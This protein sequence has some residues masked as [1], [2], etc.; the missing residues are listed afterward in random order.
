V[1]V[2]IAGGAGFLGSHLT[3]LHVARGDEVVVLDDFTTG[4]REN[5][6]H[7]ADNSAVEIIAA[8]VSVEVPVSGSVDRVYN[9][10]SPASPPAY[11]ERPL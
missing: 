9:L 1:R 4:T 8:D 7:L 6:A 2:V 5:V 11:L 3:D 10:A